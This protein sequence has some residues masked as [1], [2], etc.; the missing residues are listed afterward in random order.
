M[1]VHVI[2]TRI[3]SKQQETEEIF[4]IPL[5]IFQI[6]FVLDFVESSTTE[7]V[8]KFENSVRM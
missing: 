1:H 8:I 7:V 2:S 5:I 3:P 4:K 6:V